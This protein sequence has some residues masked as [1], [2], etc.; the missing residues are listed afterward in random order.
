MKNR[1]DGIICYWRYENPNNLSIGR[2]VL[3]ESYTI[4]DDDYKTDGTGSRTE[5]EN[6]LYTKPN[7]IDSIPINGRIVTGWNIFRGVHLLGINLSEVPKGI[8]DLFMSKL[9][10][11]PFWYRVIDNGIH[12]IV[13]TKKEVQKYVVIHEK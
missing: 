5:Y 6:W 10:Q 3:T 2:W 8:S 11:D 1:P 4:N 9:T 13:D 7:D 12:L